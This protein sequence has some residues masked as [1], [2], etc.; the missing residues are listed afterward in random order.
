M[1]VKSKQNNLG[2]ACFAGRWIDMSCQFYV[3]YKKEK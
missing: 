3:F 2:H 1:A